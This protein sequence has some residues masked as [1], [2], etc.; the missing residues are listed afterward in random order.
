MP[1]PDLLACIEERLLG[2][3]T[4]D[5]VLSQ[6]MLQGTLSCHLGQNTKHPIGIFPLQLRPETEEARLQ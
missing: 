6:C 4:F 5:K 3:N 1:F 2:D